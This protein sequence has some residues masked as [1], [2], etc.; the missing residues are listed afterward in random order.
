MLSTGAEDGL[1]LVLMDFFKLHRIQRYKSEVFGM[2]EQISIFNLIQTDDSEW[3]RFKDN[4][5]KKKAGFMRFD[6]NGHKT[7]DK[8]YPVVEACCF[9]EKHIEKPFDNWQ[10][11]TFENCPFIRSRKE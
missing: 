2:Y 3:E 11:C 4:Y 8:D 7:G 1:A 9:R 10:P 5:C 6:N